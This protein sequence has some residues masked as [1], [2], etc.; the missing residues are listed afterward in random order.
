MSGLYGCAGPEGWRGVRAQWDSL[1]KMV[2]SF[3]INHP[4]HPSL[5]KAVFNPTAAYTGGRHTGGERDYGRLFWAHSVCCQ[6]RTL[7][8]G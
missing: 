8:E 1:T 7:H 6:W 4:D 2:S 3:A 5:F